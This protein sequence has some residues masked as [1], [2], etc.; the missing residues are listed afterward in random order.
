M[1]SIYKM[2]EVIEPC[3][4]IGGAD[5]FSHAPQELRIKCLE[6]RVAF[7]EQR[8]NLFTN[9]KLNKLDMSNFTFDLQPL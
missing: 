6:E 1:L 8:L 3:E 7:L 9:L 4:T 5:T 2:D